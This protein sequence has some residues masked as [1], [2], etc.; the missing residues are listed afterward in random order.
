VGSRRFE[1][2]RKDRLLTANRTLGRGFRILL[3]SSLSSNLAD[4]VVKVVLPLMAVRVTESPVL[5]SGVLV[6]LT[7]PWLLFALP[8]GVLVDSVDRRLAM[9]VANAL[10]VALLLALSAVV[11]LDVRS[12]WSLYAVAF[13]LG[14][15]ETM[16]DTASQSLL[17]S[18]VARESLERANGRLSAAE[19][20]SN[21]FVGPPLGG[22]LIATAVVLGV[23]AP[24]GL[25]GVAFLVLLSLRGNFKAG[26][27]DR[28]SWRTELLSGARFT[29]KNRLLRT[30]AAMVAVCNVA[31]G[32]FLGTFVVF[33]VG[34]DSAMRASDA[35]YG[36][37]LTSAGVGSLLGSLAASWT[38]LKLG[39]GRLLAL[40]LV[41]MGLFIGFPSL[42]TRYIGVLLGF[43][44]GGAAVA[45]WNVV[46]VSF[47]QRVTPDELLGRVNSFYR[48]LT[49]GT[50]PLGSLLGGVLGEL[51][52]MQI[53]FAMMT[54][55]VLL[56]LVG[57]CVVNE[58]G[59][60][61]AEEQP[62]ARSSPR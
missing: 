12:I 39:R 10:R 11:V 57:L 60:R 49:W 2:S 25:W 6:A 9:L 50:V 52:G 5:V 13:M 35:E 30:M 33:A 54:V 48:L 20:T 29:L 38:G 24:A 14:A 43:F 56:P 18:V 61:E 16:Y 23:A 1:A 44:L 28:L 37:L 4:G 32:A 47:R 17:P 15:A 27:G 42:T 46:T 26:K 58:K 31:T 34:S 7:L 62:I 36:L 59:L 55:V 51:V 3:V 45:A 22:L 41:C 19:I 8:V 40:T 53:M 21:L